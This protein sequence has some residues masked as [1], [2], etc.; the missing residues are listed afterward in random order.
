M[1]S[2]PSQPIIQISSANSCKSLSSIGIAGMRA[3]SGIGMGSLRSSARASGIFL[4]SL[5]LYHTYGT[6]F[7]G[8]SLFRSL[9][10]SP[11]KPTAGNLKLRSLSNPNAGGSK[12]NNLSTRSLNKA[13]FREKV[14]RKREGPLNTLPPSSFP[15]SRSP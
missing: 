11:G 8:F 5:N 12:K 1:A 14:R 9:L 7:S 3:L 6:L 4:P 10:R 15:R 2:R 13:C